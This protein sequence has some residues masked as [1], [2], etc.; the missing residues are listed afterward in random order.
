MR[1]GIDSRPFQGRLAGTGRYVLELCRALDVCLPEADFIIYGNRPFDFPFISDRWK[2]SLDNSA[3]L[4]RMPAS[5]WYAER[6]G[7]FVNRDAV[8]VF[9]GAA[10]FLPRSLPTKCRSLITIHDLVG[11][12]M[13]DT[14]SFN[15]QVYNRMYFKSGVSRATAVM[16]NSYGTADRLFGYFGRQTDVVV[17]PCANEMFKPPLSD[18]II[19]VRDRYDLHSNFVLAVATLEPRKN[20]DNLIKAMMQLKSEQDIVVPDLVLVG[21]V[22]WKARALLELIDSARSCGMRVLQ[23]GFVPDEDLPALYAASSAFVF[24]SRYEGFGMPV[25]EALKC[26]AHVL[27]SDVPEIREAGGQYPT[28]FEPSLTGITNALREFLCSDD[29]LK[30]DPARFDRLINQGSTWHQQGCTLAKMMK[31]LV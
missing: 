15:H 13:P 11:I 2:K 25:L 28:Y 1:I 9:W 23:T 8:D 18:E 5:I 29:Y 14:L 30:P 26:G 24:P 16:T 19:R 3:F 10:N 12:L 31:S 17:H 22:G 6:V 4:S 20:L 7:H 21:Q 27:A